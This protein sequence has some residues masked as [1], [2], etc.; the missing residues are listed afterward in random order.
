VAKYT[1]VD[2][3]MASLPGERR[4]VMEQ[5][6]STIRGAAPDATE[7]IAY[8]MPALRWEGRFLVSYEAYKRHYSIFPWTDAML[9]ELGDELSP[10]AVGKGTLRFPANRPIPL[11][12]VTR[13][14][15]IRLRDVTREASHP[16]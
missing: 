8:N 14:I 10:Y 2:E 15:E 7:A 1:S 11:D 16:R 5:M 12:L 9:A 4:A 6:R 3:Y 13:I